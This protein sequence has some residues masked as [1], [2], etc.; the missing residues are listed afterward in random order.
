MVIFA[1]G[2]PLVCDDALVGALGVSGAT[3]DEDHRVGEATAR[4]FAQSGW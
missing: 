2:I 1:G 4:I 3:V